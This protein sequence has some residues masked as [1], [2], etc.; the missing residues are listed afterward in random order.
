MS[1]ARLS[2]RQSRLLHILAED[3]P[4]P[5]IMRLVRRDY[6]GL[7]HAAHYATIDRLVARRFVARE[8]TERGHVQL[9]ITDAGLAA[10]GL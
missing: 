7:G 6:S 9:S 4:M 1:N 8:K 2:D 5:S 10:I 3:G